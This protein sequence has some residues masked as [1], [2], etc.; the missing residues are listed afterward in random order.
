MA[1]QIFQ[2]HTESLMAGVHYDTKKSGA[3]WW[4]LIIDS[5][6]TND[7]TDTAD[8]VDPKVRERNV[9]DDEED[10]E[11]DDDDEIGMHFD[12]DYGL[13]EQLPNNMLHPRI[14]TVSYLSDIGI[15]TLVLNKR[16]PPPTD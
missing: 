8:S 13:E 4:T 6:D 15:P 1:L 12:A 10:D 2:A 14:A 11:N 16:S 7:A 3:E 9:A 5:N